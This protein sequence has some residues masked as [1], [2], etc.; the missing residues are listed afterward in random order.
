MTAIRFTRNGYSFAVTFAY[1]PAVVELLKSTVPYYAR[2][3]SPDR[4]EW[5]VDTTWVESLA[6]ALGA[7]GHTIIGLEPPRP[8]ATTESAQWARLLFNRVGPSRTAAV[9]RA[10]SKCLPPDTPTG[11]TTQQRELNDAHS[12]WADRN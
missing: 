12:V 3:W 6:A 2:S 9:Y 4:R 10:Q 7:A 5:E 8:R 11:D 1:N